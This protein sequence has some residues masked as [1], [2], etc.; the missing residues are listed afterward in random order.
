MGAFLTKC[1]STTEAAKL[2]RIR[3][4]IFK[5][6]PMQYK[7]KTFMAN[8]GRYEYGDVVTSESSKGIRKYFVVESHTE[9]DE[10]G[11]YTVVMVK[12]SDNWFLRKIEIAMLKKKHKNFH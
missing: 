9:D 5:T 10:L 7:I 8:H 2:P 6:I 3:A 12:L 4:A 11:T 1:L